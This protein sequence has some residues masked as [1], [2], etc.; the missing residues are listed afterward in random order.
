MMKPEERIQKLIKLWY[1]VWINRAPNVDMRESSTKD[2]QT[3]WI[4]YN[5]YEV[6]SYASGFWGAQ[7]VDKDGNLSIYRGTYEFIQQKLEAIP[8][9]ERPEFKG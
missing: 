1:S 7:V 5:D 8:V 2:E 6:W 4:I 3:Y 9:R